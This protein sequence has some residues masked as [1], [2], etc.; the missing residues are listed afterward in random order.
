MV[1]VHLLNGN[2]RWM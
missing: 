2:G 1:L